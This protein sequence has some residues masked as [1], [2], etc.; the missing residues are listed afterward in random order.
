MWL[1]HRKTSPTKLWFGSR[2]DLFL[3]GPPERRYI[4]HFTLLF[5]FILLLVVVGAVALVPT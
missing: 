5:F 3:A 1:L 4:I 2:G